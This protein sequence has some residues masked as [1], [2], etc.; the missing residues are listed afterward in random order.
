MEYLE[1]TIGL[2]TEPC[3]EVGSITNTKKCEV[4]EKMVDINKEKKEIK[5]LVKEFLA[6]YKKI[7]GVWK[8]AAFSI[9]S[10]KPLT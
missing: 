7:D 10:D 4:K 5:R 2:K 6:V 1:P 9:S 3:S 8:G